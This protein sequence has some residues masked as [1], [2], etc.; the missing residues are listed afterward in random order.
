MRLKLPGRFLGPFILGAAL[1]AVPLACPPAMGRAGS[2]HDLKVELEPET[3]G[4]AA[5]DEILIPEPGAGDLTFSIAKEARIRSVS[6]ENGKL[7]DSARTGVVAVSPDPYAGGAPVRVRIAYEAVFDDPVAAEPDS[8]DNPGFGVTGTIGREGVFLLP[9]SGW[10]PRVPGAAAD[11]RIEVAA[12]PGFYAVTAGEPVAHTEGD[13]RS[14]STWKAHDPGQGLALS[15]GKYIVRSETAGNVPI[16]TY[17]FPQTD[18]LSETYRK[19]AASHIQ[20][21]ERLH[22]PYPFPKFA[23]VENFFP[24]GYGFPSYTLLGTTVLRLPFIPGTSLRHEVAHSWWG[25]GV[26]VDY[27][28]GNW[29]EGLTTYVSDYLSRER[30]SA[31]EGKLYRRQLLEDYATLVGPGEDFPLNRFVSRTSPATRAVGYGKAAFVFHMIRREL[32][33]GPFWE[34]LRHVF[35]KRLLQRTSWEDFEEAFVEVGGWD[36]RQAHRF[37]GQWLERSGAPALRLDGVKAEKEAGSWGVEGVI[38]QTTPCFELDVK[39]RLETSAGAVEQ[40]LRVRGESTPFRFRTGGTP[41][42]LTVDP[43]RDLFRY[44]YP[45][46]IPASVNGIKGSR[47]LAAVLGDGA[48]PGDREIFLT[49]LAGLN[50][51]DAVVLRE[52]EVDLENM[53]DRDFLFFGFPRSAGLKALFDRLPE[54]LALSADGFSLAGSFSGNP[55]DCLFVTFADAGR[56]GKLTSLFLPLPGADA[57]SR[58]AAGRKITHY[59][60]YGYLVFTQGANRVKGSWD[61]AASELSRDFRKNPKR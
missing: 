54:G 60:R 22:G 31:A 14:V 19:A 20:F 49:M 29:C 11:L 52:G 45:D 18:P 39:L 28:S 8:F 36:A 6:V 53:K 58:V 34:S 24:T 15:A 9:A 33:D 40:A 30:V 38:S 57:A 23:V 47:Q 10:Y 5:V 4:L 46:E 59:G 13:G 41:E 55:S 17:F 2:L 51:E 43:D 26:L 27:D 42:R 25:N 50:H 1:C 3:H 37:F 35:K 44:L 56:G 32:G 48:S 7:R 61:A 12:P 21:Y 16:F